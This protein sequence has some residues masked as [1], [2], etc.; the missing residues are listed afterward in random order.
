MKYTVKK[1]S[2]LYSCLTPEQQELRYDIIETKSTKS[3]LTTYHKISAMMNDGNVY[4]EN[5]LPKELEV[6]EETFGEIIEKDIL[7][8]LN[9][10]FG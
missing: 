1:T 3:G 8:P 10:T 4:T 7:E 5:A 9:K 6:V 2:A